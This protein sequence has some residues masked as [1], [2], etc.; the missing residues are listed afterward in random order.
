MKE[1]YMKLACGACCIS[2]VR[3]AITDRITSLL[4]R[5]NQ[6]NAVHI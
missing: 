1:A 5:R 4:I 6:E 3:N 2:R